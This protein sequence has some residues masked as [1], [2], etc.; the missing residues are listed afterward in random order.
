MLRC[1][2]RHKM[3]RN[4]ELA[5][6]REQEIPLVKVVR[7]RVRGAGGSRAEITRAVRPRVTVEK[8]VLHQ[9]RRLCCPDRYASCGCWARMANPSVAESPS[10]SVM[11]RQLKLSMAI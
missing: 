4:S 1:D 10:D 5:Q 8:I 6:A 9:H 3:R 11:D 7:A 2:S